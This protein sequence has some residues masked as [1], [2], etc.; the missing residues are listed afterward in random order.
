[1]RR[2]SHHGKRLLRVQVK[3]CFRGDR[4]RRTGFTILVACHGGRNYSVDDVDFIAAFI[5]KYDIWYLIPMES[6]GQKRSIHAYPGKRRS[7]DGCGLYEQYRESWHLLLDEQNP[8][9]P[10][11]P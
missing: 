1:M 10:R 8:T 11:H 7:R 5:A 6:L 2:R 4:L 3:S 9:K